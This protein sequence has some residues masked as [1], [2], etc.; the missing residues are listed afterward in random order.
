MD[1]TNLLQ[2]L[3]N[4]SAANDPQTQVALNDATQEYIVN[5]ERTIPSDWPELLPDFTLMDLLE[6]AE[7]SRVLQED[8]RR[9]A[10]IARLKALMA[11]RKAAAEK[12][13]TGASGASK[14]EFSKPLPANKIN[15][16]K[17]QYKAEVAEMGFQ[18]DTPLYKTRFSAAL[19]FNERKG[20]VASLVGR[21][22]NVFELPFAGTPPDTPMW[23]ARVMLYKDEKE[24]EE[25]VDEQR[26]CADMAVQQEL[27]LWDGRR[28]SQSETV[29][30]VGDTVEDGRGR[31]VGKLS[32]CF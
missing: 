3:D 31:S 28:R 29:R 21:Q 16:K 4:W 30:L 14:S 6:L 27:E 26:W 24:H 8:D 13:V 20:S 17:K 9:R 22:K 25:S 18:S 19:R 7:T 10:S 15:A 11:K 5:W 12:S 32:H 2:I 23:N 1:T